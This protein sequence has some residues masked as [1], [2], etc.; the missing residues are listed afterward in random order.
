NTAYRHIYPPTR[1]CLSERCINH[2]P[3]NSFTTLSDSS[4]YPAALFTLREGIIPVYATS[5]SCP[6]C[7]VRYYNNYSADLATGT[8]TYYQGVPEIIQVAEHSYMERSLLEFFSLCMLFGWLS[9]LNCA[10]IYNTAI[11]TRH[12][13]VLNNPR[14]F[15]PELRASDTQVL[16]G[17]FLYSPL[18]DYSEHNR[19]LILNHDAPS[20]AD[21]L[22][23]ALQERNRCMEG[24]G[25][26]EYTHACD[27]CFLVSVDSEG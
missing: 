3:D 13:E 9:S 24:T 12:A 14:A 5:L 18:L 10:K 20:Q 26:E 23:P 25:Q 16:N 4:T 7:R 8:R 15:P 27:A 1:V 17:F 2:C 11:A 19:I 21:R 22:R 6:E